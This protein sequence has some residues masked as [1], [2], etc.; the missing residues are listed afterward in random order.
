MGEDLDLSSCEPD[1]LGVHLQDSWAPFGSA[2]RKCGLR[3]P[4][5]RHGALATSATFRH[6]ETAP[7]L[8][9]VTSWTIDTPSSAAS[10]RS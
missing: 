6:P 4:L 9:E 7:A 1:L 10:R 8:V 2:L 3:H 5:L